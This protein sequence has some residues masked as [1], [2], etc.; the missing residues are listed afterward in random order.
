MLIIYIKNKFIII[1][2]RYKLQTWSDLKRNTREKEEKRRA[3]IAKGEK[4]TV[5]FSDIEES[6][7]KN[8]LP[9]KGFG[10]KEV[11]ELKFGKNE[12]K[13]KQVNKVTI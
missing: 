9:E 1:I 12:T 11:P 3:H 2:N 8:I 7:I 4:V 13:D 6:I 10:L 5:K